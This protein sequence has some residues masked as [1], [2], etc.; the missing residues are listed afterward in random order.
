MIWTFGRDDERLCIEPNS[1]ACTLV[2]TTPDAPP[3][4]Y[5]FSEP[6][7]LTKF[8]SDMVAFLLQTG[9]TL[10]K[11]SPERRRGRDR[12]GFP[13]LRERRRWWTDSAE[14]WKALSVAR[15]IFVIS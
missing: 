1:E 12:R 15:K 13:R 10:L 6:S 4:Q 8:Q 7:A 3:R 2:V 9:W 14:L 5:S 11:Y